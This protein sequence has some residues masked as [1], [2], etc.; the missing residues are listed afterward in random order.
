MPLG[1]RGPRPTTKIP[2][3]NPRLKPIWRPLPRRPGTM[4][5]PL[6]MGQPAPQ[7]A[8]VNTPIL[9]P[10]IRTPAPSMVNGQL[11]EY[12]TMASDL[13]AVA[14]VEPEKKPK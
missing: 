9:V 6:S 3:G 5:S 10:P 4:L 13:T 8:L 14:Q 11:V 2:H 7:P 12:G 1:N